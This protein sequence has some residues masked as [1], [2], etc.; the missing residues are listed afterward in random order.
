[1]KSYNYEILQREIYELKDKHPYL[2]TVTIGKTML[3]REIPAL[4]LG[5]GSKSVMYIGGQRGTEGL[6]TEILMCFVREYLQFY[7][8]KKQIF[9]IDTGF[10]FNTRSIFII[11]MPN[12][13]G[14]M[15]ASQGP[16][17]THLLYD[18]Q[19][20]IN[21]QQ[22]DFSEWIGN[23][24]GVDI[25]SN[26]PQNYTSPELASPPQGSIAGEYPESEPESSA[27]C[28]FIRQQT[29][30]QKISLLLALGTQNRSIRYWEDNSLSLARILGARSHLPVSKMELSDECRG[31]CRW[32]VSECCAPALGIHSGRTENDGASDA[33]R[34]YMSLRELFFTSP[35]L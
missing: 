14:N 26:Y 35:I 34:Q 4:I 21:R 33:S 30:S 10:L 24:R 15:I 18:R 11:P 12:P 20:R 25:G 8:E 1:M 13:D 28:R 6:S 32:F 19:L 7:Q 17:P 22:S 9:H 5:R 23:A 27:L 2:E 29:L 31:L 16:S 3:S